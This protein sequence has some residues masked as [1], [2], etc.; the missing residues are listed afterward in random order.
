VACDFTEDLWVGNESLEQFSTFSQFD[1]SF[2]Q[3]G[4][5]MNVDTTCA[6]TLAAML[7]IALVACLPRE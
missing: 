2:S 6:L 4:W 1:L 5:K 3:E 7:L